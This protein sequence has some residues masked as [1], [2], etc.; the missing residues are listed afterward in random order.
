VIEN[1]IHDKITVDEPTIVAEIETN[2]K[3]ALAHVGEAEEPVDPANF[4]GKPDAEVSANKIWESRERQRVS[5]EK[6]R[7]GYRKALALL[8]ESLSDEIRVKSYVEDSKTVGE[9][10]DRIHEDFEVNKSSRASEKEAILERLACKSIADL[11]VKKFYSEMFKNHLQNHIES[12][13]KIVTEFSDLSEEAIT[14]KKKCLLFLK[15]MQRIDHSG[16]KSI[17]ENLRFEF[18][19]NKTAQTTFGE[20][21]NQFRSYNIQFARSGCRK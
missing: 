8:R 17:L 18:S 3:R 12:F 21:L 2:R 1:Q 4:V 10:F 13:Q 5:R 20:L 14:D 15:S 11:T 7:N 16:V 19:T 9:L 6:V